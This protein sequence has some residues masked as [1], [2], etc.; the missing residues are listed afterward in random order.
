MQSVLSFMDDARRIIEG[1]KGRRWEAFK[2]SFS[3][4]AT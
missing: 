1:G 4:S 3:L 2:W